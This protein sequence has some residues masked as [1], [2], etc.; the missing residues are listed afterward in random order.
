M[1]ATE[2]APLVVARD[3][4]LHTSRAKV[5]GPLDLEV[6]PGS[7]HLVAGERGSGRSSLLLAL[8]GRMRGVTGSLTVDGIDALRSARAVRRVTSVARVGGLADL[9]DDL[10]VGEVIVEQALLDGLR[11]G[12]ARDRLA[13]L[14]D[15]LQIAAE[16][17]DRVGSLPSATRTLLTVALSALRPT[18][19]VV[20][21]DLDA[22]LG[23]DDV[24]RTLRRLQALAQ[25]PE[26][27]AG[28]VA[29]L[30]DPPPQP[31]PTTRLSP[32]YDHRSRIA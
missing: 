27:G 21:D 30:V 14:A 12:P 26:L 16:P 29:A 20:L 11:I 10:T 9:E 4:A 8:T 31:W 23:A 2:A 24:A 13:A 15:L 25:D 7:V 32:P 22:G 6:E 19:L 3:L 5:F 1:S 17:G 18:R 28:V